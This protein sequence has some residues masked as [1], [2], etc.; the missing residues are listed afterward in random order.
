MHK[1]RQAVPD[2]SISPAPDAQAARTKKKR[3][4]RGAL[5]CIDLLV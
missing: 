5:S 3:R 2:A 4:N 1:V